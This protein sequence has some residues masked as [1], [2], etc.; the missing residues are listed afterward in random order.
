MA[1]KVWID[2]DTGS[3]DAVALAM[4]LRDPSVEVVGIST[5]AGNVDVEQ[6]TKNALMTIGYAQAETPPVYQGCAR[7]LFHDH[8]SAVA[9]HGKDGMGDLGTLDPG[10]YTPAEERAIPALLRSARQGGLEILAL[11]PLTNLALAMMQDPDAMRQISHI[12]LM[13]GAYKRGNTGYLAEFNLWEDAEAADY[14]FSFGVPITM[15]TLDACHG[16]TRITAEDC[17]RL[18]ALGSR[19]ANFCVDCNRTLYEGN[20]AYGEPYF[21]LPDA[22]AA[23]VFLYP[24]LAR[25]AVLSYTRIELRSELAYGATVNDLRPRDQ[26]EFVSKRSV[27]PP[28][29]CRLVPAVDSEGFKQ[30]LFQLMR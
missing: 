15:V 12:T 10:P 17:T 25:N 1:K 7:P 23:A 26:I 14:V 16:E 6:A 5:V 18:R 13:G 30:L 3:D 28:Y 20:A 8:H 29:N 21:T 24:K 9:V 4:V 11:G 19:L 22:V 2:T 27:F